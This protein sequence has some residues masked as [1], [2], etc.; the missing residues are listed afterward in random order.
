MAS[1]NIEKFT[2]TEAANLNKHFDDKKRLELDH[3]NKDI[4]KDLIHLN[5]WIGW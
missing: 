4:N 1:V 5:Y 2:M 3:A